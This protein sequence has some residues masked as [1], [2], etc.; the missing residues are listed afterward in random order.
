MAKTMNP[1]PATSF[2]I[3]AVNSETELNTRAILIQN[4]AVDDKLDKI[5]KRLAQMSFEDKKSQST[6]NISHIGRSTQNQ[7]K[8]CFFCGKSGHIKRE[9]FRFQASLANKSSNPHP[10]TG[11]RRGGPDNRGRSRL[12]VSF[13]DDNNYQSHYSRGN[14]RGSQNNGYNRDRSL[15][16]NRSR[17]RTPTSQYQRENSYDRSR[18]PRPDRSRSRDRSDSFNNQSRPSNYNHNTT[19]DRSMSANYSRDNSSDRSS[20]TFLSEN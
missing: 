15:S 17:S 13:A 12:R 18:S 9:C 7:H 6:T 19:G 2:S 10:N 3:N 5:E 20:N 14:Y 16:F 1:T 11:F 4:S 8:T